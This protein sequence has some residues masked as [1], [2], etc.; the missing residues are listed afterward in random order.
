MCRCCAGSRGT[1]SFTSQLS[2]P[3]NISA[4]FDIVE[5]RDAAFFQALADQPVIRVAELSR[6]AIEGRLPFR[7][8]R[9]V[10]DQRRERRQLVARVSERESVHRRGQ[11]FEA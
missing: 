3:G 6:V 4:R 1:S 10:A 11:R 2:R 5:R 7:R 8:Q 9:A